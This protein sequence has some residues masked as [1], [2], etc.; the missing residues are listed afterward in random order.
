[1]GIDFPDRYECIISGY[2]KKHNSEK[3]KELNKI[4]SEIPEETEEEEKFKEELKNK[5]P[6]DEWEIE[7][8]FF[9]FLKNMKIKVDNKGYLEVTPSN[10]IYDDYDPICEADFYFLAK[11]LSRII[12]D[13]KAEIEITNTDTGE[14]TKYIIKPNKVIEEESITVPTELKEKIKK[15]IEEYH[16]ST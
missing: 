8:S 6:E 11:W 1:M 2:V 7:E 12:E 4:L 16:Q 3:L 10:F 13:G 15:L 5:Y 9:T 14:K